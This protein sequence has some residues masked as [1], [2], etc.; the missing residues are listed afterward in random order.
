MV[1][2]LAC[3]QIYHVIQEKVCAKGTLSMFIFLRSGTF[4]WSQLR[5]VTDIFAA[6]G[7]LFKFLPD[8]SIQITIDRRTTALC[9]KTSSAGFS[10]PLELAH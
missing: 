3:I 7:K 2:A 6:T 9:K 4:C 8:R 10:S 1:L 5:R